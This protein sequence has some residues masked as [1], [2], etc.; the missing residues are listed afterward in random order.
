MARSGALLAAILAGLAVAGLI[1]AVALPL[2]PESWHMGWLA[3]AVAG[4]AVALSVAM[5]FRE[6]AP[7]R[8]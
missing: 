6:P 8:N 5:A 4:V 2:T 1:V 7:P 3:W